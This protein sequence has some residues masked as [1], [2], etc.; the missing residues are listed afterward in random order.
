MGARVRTASPAPPAGSPGARALQKGLRASP[1]HLHGHVGD[2]ARRLHEGLGRARAESDGAA[3]LGRCHIEA[4]RGRVRGRL[5]RLAEGRREGEESGRGHARG[6]H[7]VVPD[8]RVR[9]RHL[10]VAPGP[11]RAPGHARMAAARGVL[12]RAREVG[13]R[14]PAAQE[15]VVVHAHALP[16]PGSLRRGGRRLLRMRS[17][18][19]ERRWSVRGGR[20]GRMRPRGGV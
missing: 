13:R 19:A 14:A 3:L 1:V 16:G 15:R 2:A 9:P 5:D 6:V 8:V 17:Q 20:R 11:G 7:R 4:E 10:R 18:P 12:R